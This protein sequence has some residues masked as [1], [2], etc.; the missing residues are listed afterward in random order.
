[1]EIS[2]KL[3]INALE[4]GP[5]MDILKLEFNDVQDMSGLAFSV[6]IHDFISFGGSFN[7]EEETT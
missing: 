4:C 7:E 6:S 2:F 3:F 5:H 1:M